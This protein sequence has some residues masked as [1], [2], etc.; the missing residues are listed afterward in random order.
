MKFYATLCTLLFAA[1]ATACNTCHVCL[2]LCFYFHIRFQTHLTHFVFEEEISSIFEA[3][4]ESFFRRTVLAIKFAFTTQALSTVVMRS[5]SALPPTTRSATIH[6]ALATQALAT[7]VGSE[8]ERWCW[9]EGFG[10]ELEIRSM[11]GYWWMDML[12]YEWR[13]DFLYA[14]FQLEHDHFSKR[15][16]IQRPLSQICS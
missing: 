3:L 6:E 1:V 15:A 14:T 12:G 13:G 11:M 2:L 4:T 8:I 5:L 7:K 16:M 9:Y 10:C